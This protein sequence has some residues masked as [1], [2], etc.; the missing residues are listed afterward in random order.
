MHQ[1]DV[2][3][4][5]H[6]EDV[7]CVLQQLG[8]RR[9]ERRVL[10]LRVA[11]E[12]GDAEQAGQVD[13][14]VDLV[15]LALAQAELLEQ[16]VRQVFRASV[17]NFQSHGI[18]VAAREQLTAQRTGKVVDL[19]GVQRQVGVAGQ[20]ELVAT[21]HL[22]ALEQ[23]IGV[24]MDHRR[25]EDIVIAWAANLLR[26]TN[27]ARQQAWRRDDRQAGI[28]AEGVDPFELDDEVQALVHQQ[29]ERVGRV[30]ADR[31][32]DRRDLVAEV[33]AHPGLELGCPVAATNE[34]DGVLFQ[35]RQQH[36]VE[37]RVLAL[38]LDVHQLTDTC[39]RL[40]RLQPIGAG[41]FAG[42][43]DL[44]LQAGDANLEELVE[45]AGKDQQEFEAL[46]QRVRFVQRLLQHTDVEL[47]LGK[48]AMNV[49]AAV[50]QARDGNGRRRR[51]GRSGDF[52]HR[53]DDLGQVWRGLYHLFGDC[54]GVLDR[55][56][57]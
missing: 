1:Q 28:A 16:V 32:D 22:H 47:Q 31:G 53:L 51:R 30:K 46:E 42:E 4:A 2:L 39:Q 37:D 8:D 43:V 41:Q 5:D 45:V 19:F 34:A 54:L 14:A 36:I 6:A 55:D 29:R 26:H 38:H 23:V 33:T 27:H 17:G 11:V 21:L 56:R 18:A 12:A 9:G 52:D 35:L 15:E 3:L 13:R 40:M 20:A 49:Q 57:G 50:V 7:V 10:Q 24:G 44:F 48:F 25:Q